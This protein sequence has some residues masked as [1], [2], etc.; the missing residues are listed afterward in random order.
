MKKAAVRKHVRHAKQVTYAKNRNKLHA[1]RGVK[2]TKVAKRGRKSANHY[3]AQRSDGS[4]LLMS[5]MALVVNQEDGSTIY[6]KRP[7]VRAPIASLTKIM[8]AMVTLDAH[9]P[10]DEAITIMEADV[11]TLRGSSS[12]LPVGTTLNREDMLHLALMASKIARR[13]PWRATIPAGVR[14]LSM[15]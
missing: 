15:P 11:D 1:E 12:R 13:R 5:S 4:L 8:T 10:M 6:A 14:P 2:S 9:L 7:A 3:V